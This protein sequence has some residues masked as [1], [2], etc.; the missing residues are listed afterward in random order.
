MPISL[1]FIFANSSGDE[2]YGSKS[3]TLSNITDAYNESSKDSGFI[4]EFVI[5]PD[6]K[7]LIREYGNLC[8][9]LHTDLHECVGHGSGKLMPGISKD[10]LKNHASTIEEARADLFA[11]YFIADKKLI[12]LGLLPNEDAY[13]AEYYRFFRNGL[14]TQ[15]TRVE[16]GKDLEEAHMRNRQLIAA[17][18]LDH[19]GKNE[20]SLVKIDGK[21]QLQINDYNGLRSI[22][23]DMLR[24]IQRITSEGDYKT[25]QE[26]VQTYAI[27]VNQELHLEILDR[28][29]KLN[30]PKYTGVLN[31]KYT[32]IID[33][34][35]IDETTGEPKIV[36]VMIDYAEGFIG[37]SLRYNQ[38]Y[39]VLPDIN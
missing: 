22:V 7:Q 17:W 28:Y 5:D 9:N 35:T 11:L 15:L 16:P 12:E 30:I 20:M 8:N 38:Y 32:P 36:D 39:S 29:K 2:K 27:K 37:Q 19:C 14:M 34:N 26:L 13:K 1:K 3:V 10:S 23:G 33:I 31:P 21:T 25:A 6:T 4:D 18:V 24:E